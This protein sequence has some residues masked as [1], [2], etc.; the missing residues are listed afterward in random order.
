[1]ERFKEGY[2]FFT[3]HA[4]DFSGV[5]MGENY[6][7]TVSEEIDKLIHDL[8]AFNGSG[9]RIDTLKGDVAEFWH[10]GTFNIDAAVQSSSNR[11]EVGRSH[12]LGS[13][14][15]SAKNFNGEYGLKYYKSG[16]DS[17][18]QQAKSIFERFKEYQAKGGK[19]EIEEYLAKRNYGT[20]TLLSDPIYSGQIRVIPS[21]QMDEAISWLE[22]KIA[23]EK[24]IRP[25]EVKRF[26]ETL[27]LLKDRVSDNKGNESIPLSEADAKKLADLAKTGNV[28][29]VSLQITTEELIQFKNIMQQSFKAGLSAATIT[30]VLRTAPEIYKAIMYLI[31][32][33]EID[34]DQLKKM[35]V[36][37]LTGATEG[38]IRGSVSAAL[39]ASCQAGLLGN[40]LKSVDPSIIGAV[41]VLVMDTMKNSYKVANGTITRY[42]LTN[43]LV[44]T[45]FTSTCSLVL[46]TVTQAFIEVPVL[47]YM[48]GGFVGSL[49]GTFTYSAAY[50]PAIS[51]CV[52]T[53]FTLFSLVEQNYELPEDILKEIGIDVFEY[54]KFEFEEF[55]P[56]IF[57]FEE[58]NFETYKPESF[59]ITFLRRGVIGV[60]SVRYIVN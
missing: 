53:G 59:D 42:E 52:D 10:A 55:K 18:A 44:K 21:D 41:T 32:I 43:E 36:A 12:A 7:S 50:K 19:K 4:G 30:L 23:K 3:D 60:S 54:E 15:I 51:F 34:A 45:M 1:M 25:E 16:S 28:D 57:E 27:K 2:D 49:I 46:G 11:V 48:L 5:A 26:E 33:G 17:A 6:V 24:T 58:F 22:R 47:G 14:D 35:G 56:E 40:V 13:V 38:F 9:A 8:N 39:T 37:A 31:E 29:A 20:D